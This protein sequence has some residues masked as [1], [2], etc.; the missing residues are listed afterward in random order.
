MH[1][2]HPAKVVAL[3]PR[4]A[5]SGNLAVPREQW[6]ELFGATEG[7]VLEPPAPPPVEETPKPLRNAHLSLGRKRSNDT[8]RSVRSVASAAPSPERPLSP[9]R[10]PAPVMTEATIPRIA[11]D[12]LIYYLSDRRQKLAGVIPNISLPNEK[13]LPPLSSLPAAEVHSLPDGPITDLSAE[14]VLRTAQVVY[15]SLLKVYLVARPSLVGSLCRI[16]NWCDVAEVEP[17]LREKGRIDDLRD[18]YM[19]K[20]M[21]DKALSMLYEWVLISSSADPSGKRK[22]RMIR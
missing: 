13:D 7:A 10:E 14:Q 12:E 20:Q 1:N 11:I 18:L 4:E 6:M 3:Y 22:T 21:H 16:E 5:V 19:Q 15:T 17:L 8:L 9:P 2:V